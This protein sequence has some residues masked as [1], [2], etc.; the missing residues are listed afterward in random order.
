MKKA[1]LFIL[2]ALIISTGQLMAQGFHLGI[3]AGT[4][5]NNIDGRSFKNDFKWG[6]SAG[7]FAELNFN[8]HIG[9]QPEVLFNQTRTQTASNFSEVYSQGINSRDVE[10]NYLAIP[11]LL[12]IRPVKMLSILVGPQYGI[13]INSSKNIVANGKDAFKTGE[14][15]VVGGAQINLGGFKAGAR[16]VVG[17]SDISDLGQEDKW[18]SQ[19][20]Q[21]YVGFRII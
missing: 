12:N 16:Y 2:A 7:A 17:L 21:L 11:L 1:S 13:L 14:F 19:Q 4:N 10:L 18:K 3:K 8:A 20:V 15:S 5:L 9:L 6:F